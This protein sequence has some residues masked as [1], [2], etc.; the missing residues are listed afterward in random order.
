MERSLK[1]VVMLFD[2]RLASSEEL[3]S[4]VRE[5]AVGSEMTRGP[6]L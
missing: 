2:E 6:R 5:G 1:E 4:D 3:P